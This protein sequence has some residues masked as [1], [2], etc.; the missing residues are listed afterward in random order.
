MNKTTLKKILLE[1]TCKNCIHY[2]SRDTFGLGIAEKDDNIYG[3]GNYNHFQEII[4]S[5]V[6]FSN[7]RTCDYWE[8]KIDEF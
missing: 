3:C 4:Q 5:K 6:E 1:K 7:E 8:R 2:N